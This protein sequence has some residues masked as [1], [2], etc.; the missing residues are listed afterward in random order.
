MITR[1]FW[2][3]CVVS[4]RK[5][6]ILM[7]NSN[8][9]NL[10]RLILKA[11]FLAHVMW[12]L[13]ISGGKWR[14]STYHSHT[15]THTDGDTTS[16]CASVVRTTRGTVDTDH[17]CSHWSV[18]DKPQITP[19]IRVCGKCCHTRW[20]GEGIEHLWIVLMTSTVNK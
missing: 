5:G 2:R 12:S 6:L 11:M 7:S 19:N 3:L 10:N 13:W 4:S 9:Q 1:D 14:K 17:F 15:G 18:Q 20:F 16:T 8:P